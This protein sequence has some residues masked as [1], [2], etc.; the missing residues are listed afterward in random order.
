MCARALACELFAEA[1]WGERT[2][3]KTAAGALFSRESL[4]TRV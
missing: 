4:R 1:L 3:L 2:F